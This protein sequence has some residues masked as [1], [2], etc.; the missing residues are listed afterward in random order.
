MPEKSA[1]LWI[2]LLIYRFD[3]VDVASKEKKIGDLQRQLSKVDGETWQFQGDSGEWVSFPDCANKALMVK[4][5]EGCGSCEIVIDGKTYEIDFK[6]SSQ[7]NQRTK[8]ERKIRC[9]FDLPSHWQMTDEDALKFLKDSLHTERSPGLVHPM[10]P[11]TDQD[12][13]SRLADLLNRSL[14]RHDGS[15]C[16][17]LHGSS[18]YVV[19]EAY[20]VNDLHLWRRYQRCFRSI[21]DK[22]KQHGISLEK[23]NPSVSEALTNFARELKVDLLS[24]E[25]LLLHGT[26]TFELAKAIATEGF[27][28]R[29]A[30][31]GLF[32]K[33]TYF[34]AQTCKS[35]QYATQHG[36]MSKASPQMMGTMLIARVAIGDPFYTPRGCADL[37]RPEIKNGVRADSIIARPGIPNGQPAGIQSHM[38]VVTF[39]PGQAYP[40]F[41]VKFTEE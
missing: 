34:A 13:K 30:Q 7:M 15:Q 24:N 25:R 26:R 2:P 33:G 39:D 22:H 38:E 35:A 6:K 4:F 19:T 32:G 41:I 21:Q 27:D 28:N 20:Q 9:F 12:V 29:V 17:C 16:N 37:S 18:N 1:D 5:V 40:E 31:D 36:M 23:I 8:K 14:S 3:G 11:V 10:L